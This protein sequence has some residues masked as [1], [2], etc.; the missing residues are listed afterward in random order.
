MGKDRGNG[1]SV[2]GRFGAP[3]SRIEMFDQQLVRKI[4][5]GKDSASDAPELGVNLGLTSG[6]GSLPV[7]ARRKPPAFSP[8]QHIF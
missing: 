2:A 8:Q 4:V 3:G 5:C 7:A 1:A 6:H